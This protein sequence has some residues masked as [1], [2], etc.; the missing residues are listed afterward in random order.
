MPVLEN[1][2]NRLPCLTETGI[3]TIINGPITYTPDGLPIVGR[4]PGKRNA[5][6]ITGL[7]AGLGEGGGHGWLLAQQIVHGEACYDTW[8]LDPRRFTRHANVEYT[9]LKAIED[10]QNE[11]R[12]HMPHEWRPAGRPAKTTPIYLA[13][14]AEGASFG[15]LQAVSGVRGRSFLP[16]RQHLRHRRQRGARGARARRAH[17]G[18]RIQPYRDQ[19]LQRA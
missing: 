14:K 1:V 16:L 18:Q 8:C 13:L 7:R 3:H 4:I 9:A 2:F 19:R 17:G 6:A 11:F 15:L 10:Y 5:W 12:F